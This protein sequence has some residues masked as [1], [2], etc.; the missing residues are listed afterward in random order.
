[1]LNLFAPTFLG[2]ALFS[3]QNATANLPSSFLR[4]R[5]AAK[6]GPLGADIVPHLVGLTNAKPYQQSYYLAQ[7]QE[8]RMKADE[9]L[10]ARSNSAGQI[11]MDLVGGT[12]ASAGS[13]VPSVDRAIIRRMRYQDEAVMLLLLVAYMGSLLFSAN[14][15]YRQACNESPVTYY[16]DPR[17]FTNVLCGS[18]V[19]GFMEA[20][21]QPPK[22]IQLQI[23]GL[24]PVDSSG[25]DFP[26]PGP[27]ITRNGR[28]YTVAFAFG[29][30]LTP[31][32]EKV[33]DNG[34]HQ[35]HDFDTMTF[36]QVRGSGAAGGILRELSE[37][38]DGR[39]PRSVSRRILG[40]RPVGQGP[41]FE[42]RAKLQHY[43]AND[44]ND[45][46]IVEIEKDVS[47]PDWEELAMN[48]K[49]MFRQRGFN[50]VIHITR[51]PSEKMSVYKNRP[52]A[53]FMHSRTT[54]V[55]CALSVIGLLLHQPYMWFR[56]QVLSVRSRYRVKLS[57]EEY[58]PYICENL[59]V[60]G[61]GDS[62]SATQA[63]N[64]RARL[65]R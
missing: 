65:D 52:W 13:S 11:I 33:D 44:T 2:S 61:F 8:Q 57:I 9:A 12:G 51:T 22:D 25:F 23:M 47:W 32:I 20:F 42:E 24:E 28:Y 37:D 46:S 55:I 60:D 48:I 63:Q 17:Y 26:P 64:F 15:A 1:M 59:N 40:L 30:D 3:Q 62:A 5:Q 16:A 39:P 10:N 45:L 27:A 31:W 18:E 36:P 58:W 19:E 56:C 29:L 7:L 35:P 6:T 14:I 34:G 21:D 38:V 41:M 50:G 49:L 43:L 54:R 53:N 4:A